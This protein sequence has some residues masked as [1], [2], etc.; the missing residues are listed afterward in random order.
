MQAEPRDDLRAA[1]GVCRREDLP[2]GFGV[3]LEELGDVRVAG[4]DAAGF[5][6]PGFNQLSAFSLQLSV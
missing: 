5:A 2:S 1:S 4:A 6:G 3:F